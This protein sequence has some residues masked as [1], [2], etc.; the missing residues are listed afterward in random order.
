M[1]FQPQHNLGTSTESG[2]GDGCSRRFAEIT[3]LPPPSQASPTSLSLSFGLTGS[4]SKEK[5]SKCSDLSFQV[6]GSN[7]P[8]LNQQNTKSWCFSEEKGINVSDGSQENEMGMHQSTVNHHHVHQSSSGHS[9]KLCARG[10]W[11]PAEDTRLKELVTQYGKSCRLRWFNQLD[12]R[13]NRRA[14]GEEEEERLL[15]AHRLY[16][17]RWAM[18]AKLFPGRTD[19]AVKNHWHVIMARKQ[20]EQSNNLCR[21]PKKPISPPLPIYDPQT[22]SRMKHADLN[23]IRSYY[24][25]NACSESTVT[26]ATKDDH[27]SA[28]TCTNLSLNSSATRIKPSIFI[29][30]NQPHFGSQMGSFQDNM[31]SFR[32]RSLCSEKMDVTKNEIFKP[33]DPMKMVMGLNHQSSYSDSNSEISA[34]NDTVTKKRKLQNANGDNQANTNVPFIDF[35]GVGTTY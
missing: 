32:N 5:M 30:P 22:L 8:P 10:H 4:S 14:F 15:A 12:P 33:N 25:K 7:T 9:S 2:G 20:R 34:S 29:S 19:N 16:G 35:L 21:R 17:N 24:Q 27:Q 28:S 23:L 31:L 3:F 6:M 18:I 13:I 11:R 26:S 1:S